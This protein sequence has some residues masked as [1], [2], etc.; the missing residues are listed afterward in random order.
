MTVQSLEGEITL[1]SKKCLFPI[2][3][4]GNTT[5]NGKTHWGR[6]QLC[7][8]TLKAVGIIPS[9]SC[10]A[11]CPNQD[12]EPNWSPKAQ[13]KDPLC[14]LATVWA[15]ILCEYAEVDIVQIGVCQTPGPLTAGNAAKQSMK[16]F[17]SA[18]SQMGSISELFHLEGWS[19]S[20]VSQSHYPYFN[21]GLAIYQG[22]HEKPGTDAGENWIAGDLGKASEGEEE[23]VGSRVSSKHFRHLREKKR[24]TNS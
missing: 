8:C 22:Q 6:T 20:S 23:K 16:L 18:P 9:S 4:D 12:K 1:P 17:S 15:L 19:V 2:R 3:N 10:K 14:F 13:Q 5:D 7:T 24:N 21:T 11:S